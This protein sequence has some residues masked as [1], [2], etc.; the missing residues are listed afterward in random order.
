MSGGSV[1]RI[2]EVTDQMA[3]MRKNSIRAAFNAR[4][5]ANSLKRGMTVA[6]DNVMALFEE[7]M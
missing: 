5:Q 6:I 3:L 1:Q 4:A 2:S 7:R